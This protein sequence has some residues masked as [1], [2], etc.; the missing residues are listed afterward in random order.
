MKLFYQSCRYSV[1]CC[2]G[3]RSKQKRRQNTFSADKISVHPYSC[4][5][6]NF[7]VHRVRMNVLLW[8]RWCWPL[9]LS[10]QKW[11]WHFTHSIKLY[12]IS[13]TYSAI[14]PVS[15]WNR[16]LWAI[17]CDC[18]NKSSYELGHWHSIKQVV[19]M[20]AV[21]SCSIELFHFDRIIE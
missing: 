5:E 15:S 1:C 9:D 3:K 21:I 4:R 10:L 16:I 7:I 12:F 19:K 2:C 6:L 18:K 14:T 8:L 17:R 13:Y 20:S 11:K